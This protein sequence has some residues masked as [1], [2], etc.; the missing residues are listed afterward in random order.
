MKDE[1]KFLEQLRQ[2]AR[3]RGDIGLFVFALKYIP[4]WWYWRYYLK[5]LKN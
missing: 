3:K 4:S 1:G 2:A 5:A